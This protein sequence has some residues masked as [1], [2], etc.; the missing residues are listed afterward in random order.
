MIAFFTTKEG[1]AG[2]ISLTASV[3]REFVHSKYKSSVYF[4]HDQKES[5]EW[6][7]VYWGRQAFELLSEPIYA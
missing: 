5:K 1:M 7:S 4:I 6:V 2:E 3:N